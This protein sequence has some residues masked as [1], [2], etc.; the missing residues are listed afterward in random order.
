LSKFIVNTAKEKDSYFL[1]LDEV[2]TVSGKHSTSKLLACMYQ[3]A[4]TAMMNTIDDFL[5]ERGYEVLARVHDAIF[6]RKQLRD[7][8]YLDLCNA[9]KKEFCNEYFGIKQTKLQA[10]QRPASLDREELEQH[11]QRIRE[12]ELEAREVNSRGLLKTVFEWV[13]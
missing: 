2:K 5:R 3:H 12:E 6:V 1:K 10:F 11:R 4:E 9:V 7:D 13:S 8:D